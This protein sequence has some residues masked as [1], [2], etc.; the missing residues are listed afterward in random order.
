[1][2]DLKLPI[3]YQI[4]YKWIT[5]SNQKAKIDTVDKNTSNYVG[6]TRDVCQIQNHKNVESK[7]MDKDKPCKP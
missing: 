3:S 7:R 5:H 1:M 2:A 4:K 6:I